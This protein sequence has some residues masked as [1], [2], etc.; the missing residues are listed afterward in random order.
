MGTQ[1]L[2]VTRNARQISTVQNSHDTMRTHKRP[3]DAGNDVEN[4]LHVVANFKDDAAQRV[5][6][7]TKQCA[8]CLH[9]EEEAVTS[10]TLVQ[11]Y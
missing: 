3:E 5:P 2:Y 10:T 7:P 8:P 4:A 1:S 11:W 9:K 6:R